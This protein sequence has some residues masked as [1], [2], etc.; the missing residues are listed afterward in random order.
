MDAALRLRGLAK[1]FGTFAL[2]D[3]DLVVPRGAITG[4][5]GANGAGKSTLIKLVLGL[6]VPDAG[7]IRLLGEDARAQGAALRARIG[8]VQESPTLPPHLRI[9]E[10]GALVAP[11]YPTWDAPGFRRLVDHFDIPTKTPFAK[12]SQG[13]RMKTALALALS[14]HAELLLLDEPT[15]GLDPLARRDVLDLLLEVIQDEQKAVLF[16]THITT[17][18][19]RI[20]DHVAILK[21]GRLVLEGTKDDLLERWVLVKG[22]E[23]LLSEPVLARCAGG[24]RTALGLVLLCEDLAPELLPEGAILERPRLED[25]VAF[26]GRALSAQGT[27]EEASCCP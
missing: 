6:L 2:R 13:Q 24:E 1:A 7:E 19:D 20:A 8:F 27:K 26:H 3:L 25:L 17:D 10:L 15:S 11:F 12:L 18:L 4:L 22:G 5:V 14:H 16:S 23:E 21:A 9:G